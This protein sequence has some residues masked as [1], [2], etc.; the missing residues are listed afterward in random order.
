MNI[1]EN[2]FFFFYIT[3]WNDITFASVT[4]IVLKRT[5]KPLK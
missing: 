2:L 5:H 4:H 3:K 1:V